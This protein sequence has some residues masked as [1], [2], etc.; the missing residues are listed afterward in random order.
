MHRLVNLLQRDEGP[1]TQIEELGP[2][3]VDPEGEDE[4]EE[5][6]IVEV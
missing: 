5:E 6:G 1:E 4:E 2:E 3:D